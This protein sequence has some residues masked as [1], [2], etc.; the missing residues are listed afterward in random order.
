MTQV[1]VELSFSWFC[2]CGDAGDPIGGKGGGAAEAEAAFRRHVEQTD[3]GHHYYG[4]VVAVEMLEFDHG[5]VF[6]A[7][8]RRPIN[9]GSLDDEDEEPVRYIDMQWAW[10]DA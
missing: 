2:I 1:R 6:M 3:T 9:L 10:L 4:A 8:D 5:A 7:F